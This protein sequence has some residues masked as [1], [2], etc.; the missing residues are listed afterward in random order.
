MAITRPEQKRTEEALG[1]SEGF[2][3]GW[4]FKE[5]DR[6]FPMHPANIESELFSQLVINVEVKS[7][8][9]LTN[10]V[11]QFQ[12]LHNWYSARHSKRGNSQKCVYNTVNTGKGFIVFVPLDMNKMVVGM[13][14]KTAFA[15]LLFCFVQVSQKFWFH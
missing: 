8:L 9:Y 2:L 13:G 5:R 6:L 4:K 7:L 11:R 15:F 1:C 10:Y 12:C 3:K 14:T